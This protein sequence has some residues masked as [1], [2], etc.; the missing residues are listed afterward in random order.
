M[1][2]SEIL[3]STSALGAGVT[4]VCA[5]LYKGIRAILE[6]HDE[7]LR[8]RRFKY[9]SYLRSES[10]GHSDLTAF[11]ES[12]KHESLFAATYGRATPPRLAL[13]IMSLYETKFFSLSE[14]RACFFY[15]RISDDGLINI[16]P[17]KTGIFIVILVSSFLGFM[18]KR[19]GNAVLN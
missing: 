12:A 14:L 3:N 18:G 11:I 16:S 10:E 6:F 8:K 2:L 4:A 13:A 15:M 1:D 5:A 17:G 7:Y 19:S 9:L